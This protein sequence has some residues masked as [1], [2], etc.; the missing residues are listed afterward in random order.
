MNDSKPQSLP[1]LPPNHPLAAKIE[2]WEKLRDELAELVAQLE[3]VRLMLKLR[4]R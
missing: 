1:A 4:Q 2:A 3:T